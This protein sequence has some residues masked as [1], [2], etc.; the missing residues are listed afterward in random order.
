MHDQ[1]VLISLTCTFPYPVLCQLLRVEASLV[2]GCRVD[3]LSP[4][5]E[6]LNVWWLRGVTQAQ[7]PIGRC[8]S[9]GH[10]KYYDI[11]YRV[12]PNCMAKYLVPWP[13]TK[14]P[15]IKEEGKIVWLASRVSSIIWGGRGRGTFTYSTPYYASPQHELLREQC[16]T[17]KTW[18]WNQLGDDTLNLTIRLYIIEGPPTLSDKDIHSVWEIRNSKKTI[19]TCLSAN[20]LLN[21][22]IS[23]GVGED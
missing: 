14:L 9:L 10:H 20:A 5:R 19:Y 18:L 7:S 3:N 17:D 21:I 16:E 2:C 12:N 4:I 1:I 15:G 23:R 22:K 6:C 8:Y 13:V 11:P